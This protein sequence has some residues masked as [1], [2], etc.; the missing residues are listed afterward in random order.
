MMIRQR[1]PINAH[2]C[3]PHHR[4]ELATNHEY[5]ILLSASFRN[6]YAS[7]PISKPFSGKRLLY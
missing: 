7:S 4:Y 5:C 2:T 1:D 3:I 6:F